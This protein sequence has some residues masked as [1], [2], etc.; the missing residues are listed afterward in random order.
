M[1]SGGESRAGSARGFVSPLHF[2]YYPLAADRRAASDQLKFNYEKIGLCS[3]LRN[4]FFYW[5]NLDRW[6]E[7]V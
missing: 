5:F 2:D 7:F 1:A 3:A 4:K 6:M